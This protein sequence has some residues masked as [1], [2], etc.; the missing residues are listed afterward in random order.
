MFGD[1]QVTFGMSFEM[2]MKREIATAAEVHRRLAMTLN[3]D[4]ASTIS[5]RAETIP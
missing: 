1:I 2:R 3:G 4:D 5:N